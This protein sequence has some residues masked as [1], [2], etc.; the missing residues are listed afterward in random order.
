MPKLNVMESYFIKVPFLII[1]FLILA[2]LFLRFL[3]KKN[4]YFPLRTIDAT[5]KE[6]GLDY[7]T[8]NITTEDGVEISGWF[9]SAETPRAT[10]IFC[11]GNGGNISHRLDKIKILSGLNLDVF[12]FDY[13]GY[14]MSKGSPSEKG[15]YLDAESVYNYLINVEKLSPQKII[16]FGESLG[17]A[18]A[19]DLAHKHDMAGVIL[20]GGFTSVGDMAKV[21]FPFVPTFIYA[22]KFNAF[23]KIKSVKSPKLIFHSADDEIVPFELGKK[24][25]NAAAEPK[26][27]VKIQGGHNGAFLNSQDVF[28]SRIN[29]F[30]RRIEK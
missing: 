28:A 22:S 26:E 11:H 20:E 18:V 7:E 16:V 6:I 23:E 14:G 15:L 17:S 2:F 24:L 27:F 5:P 4:L 12:I 9:I 25:F 1:V 13:R 29:E 19:V 30:V 3:E 10:I 8:V 21:I